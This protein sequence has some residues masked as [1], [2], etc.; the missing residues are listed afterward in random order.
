MVTGVAI[1]QLVQA[2][3]VQLE[4]P[5]GKYLPDYPNKEVAAVT[6][7]QLLTHTGGTG[8]IFSP[9]FETHRAELK[10]LSDYI[11]LYAKRG[12]QFTPGSDWDYSNY[13]FVLLGRVIEVASG[14]SYYDYVRDHIFRPAGMNSTDNLPE[15]EPVPGLSVGYTGPGG[16]GLHLIGPGPGSGGSPP[17]GGPGLHLVGPGASP[18]VPPEAPRGPL[19]STKGSLPYRGTSAG[20]GYSTVGDLLKFVNALSAHKLLDAQ[21]TEL[22]TSGKVATRRPGIKYAFGFE[23]ETMR[24]GVRRFGHGGG[25]PGMNGR[26]SV[27]PESNYV[28]IALA[29]IDPPAADSIAQFICDKLLLK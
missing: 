23:D 11:A 29:N 16:P 2:G 27:F 8:D 12:V 26:L 6:I 10:E 14:Q 20:G 3:N 18:E 22:L 25:A 4:D 17:P 21:Y 1:L 15:T 24:E 28:V 7:Y 13:G 5:I 9:E 19:Q